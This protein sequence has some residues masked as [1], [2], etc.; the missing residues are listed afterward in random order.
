M[1]C[2]LLKPEAYFIVKA[3]YIKAAA[4]RLFLITRMSYR[5]AFNYCFIGL[6]RIPY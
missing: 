6:L 3:K 4:M 2:L 5:F 1:H